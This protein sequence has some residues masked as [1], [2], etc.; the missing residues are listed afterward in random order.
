MLLYSLFVSLM[1][2]SV[3]LGLD[4]IWWAQLLCAVSWGTLI[5]LFPWV[6]SQGW[7]G[8][9]AHSWQLLFFRGVSLTVMFAAYMFSIPYLSIGEAVLLKNTA[10]LFVPLT[11]KLLLRERTNRWVI[12]GC[13]I[14]FLGI[15]ALLHPIHHRWNIGWLI[16]LLGG[17]FAAF[18]L[19]LTNSLTA[20]EPPQRI[21][22]YST[23]TMALFLTP[24]TFSH[25]Q[26]LTE[27]QWLYISF[28]VVL[29]TLAGV[30]LVVALSFG[31]AS[32]LAPLSYFSICF[33]FLWGWMAF[34]ESISIY[35]LLGTLLVTLGSI[36]SI[37]HRA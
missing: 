1:A 12:A 6:V 10:P 33:S 28:S 35:V 20:R 14:G 24:V 11:A 31:P 4:G 17:F 37:W 23:L 13:I 25:W 2:L 30:S 3:R 29:L 26:A 18:N 22:F 19:V 21:L 15:A 5:L 16:G 27:P 36:M 8:L 34:N 32:R 9:V 7:R